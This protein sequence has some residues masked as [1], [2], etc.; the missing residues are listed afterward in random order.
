VSELQG[1]NSCVAMEEKQGQV[2]CLQFSFKEL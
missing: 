1:N 2:S